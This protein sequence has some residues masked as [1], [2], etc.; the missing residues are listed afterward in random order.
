MQATATVQAAFVA[1]VAA[2]FALFCAGTLRVARTEGRRGAWRLPLAV[3]AFWIV[4][5][6]VLAAAGALDRYAPLPTLGTGLF[7]V[8]TIATAAL[9]FSRPGGRLA[10]G[11]PLAALVGFQ[12]FRVPLEL[13]LHALYTQGVIPVQMT[14]SGRNLDIV[15]GLLALPVAVLLHR[16]RCPRALLA[17]WNLLGL[18]LLV[19]IVG[20][21]ILS[22][23]VPSRVFHD[24]PPNLLPSTFPFVWLPTFLVQAALFGH[25]LVFRRLRSG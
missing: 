19:N 6:G 2:V 5:P 8:L 14:Y 23:P 4:L 17:A 21:A 11:L 3:F 25:L 12:V 7:V 18:I 13:V 20:V 1:I 10:A 24:G 22:T 9:A 15:T 16:R